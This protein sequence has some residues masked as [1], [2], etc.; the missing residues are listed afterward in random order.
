MITPKIP[1]FVYGGDYNPEQWPEE[2][3]QEDMRLMKQAGVNLVNIGMW[4]WALL[5][6]KE[7]QYTFDYLDRLMD[8]LAK[9]GI[10]ADLATPT[11]APPAWMYLKHPDLNPVNV[12]GLRMNHGSRQTFCPNSP[13]FRQESQKIVRVLAEHYKTHPALAMWHVNNEY[14]HKVILCHCETCAAQF[15]HWLEERY[16]SLSKVNDTWGASFWGQVYY[17]WNEIIPPRLTA[18][19]VNPTLLL[20]YKRFMTDSYLGCY[21]LEKNI[22]REL[23]PNTPVTTN[24]LYEFRTMD[25]FK[26]AKQLDFIAVSAFPDPK[27][28]QHSG[29]AAL[30]ADVMRGLKDQ[31]PFLLIEQAANNVN[32]RMGNTNKRPGVMRLWSYQ[33]IAHGSEGAMFFQWRQSQKGAEKFHSAIV[34]HSGADTRIFREVEQLGQEFKRLGSEILDARVKA[35]VALMIDY[36]NWWTVEYAP[37]PTLYLKYLEQ[38]QNYYYPLYEQNIAVDVVSCL[39]DL[40]KYALVIAPTL[41]MVKPGVKENIE[42][43]VSN[44]GVF[45]TTFSSG[46]ADETDTVF[47]GGYPGPFKEVLGLWVEEFDA[48]KPYMKN[49]VK[50]A[51]PLGQLQNEYG[52]NLWCDMLHPTTAK[53]LATFGEDYYAGWPCIT[54]NQFGQGFAYYIATQP[55][56]NFRKEFLNY[57]CQR[58]NIKPALE[59]P[60]NV[61]VISRVKDGKEFIFVLNH[62]NETVQVPL[63]AGEYEDLLGLKSI[64][65]E[66]VLKPKDV[67]IL[68]VKNP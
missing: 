55:D 48:L 53:T 18:H 38:L 7:G 46:M 9:N 12:N 1:S 40:G 2:I 13:T 66:C 52:C 34:S 29:E 28:T 31:Q 61:E 47:P 68:T 4:N 41:Y 63:P 3:W 20:D 32:W 26:W 60:A 49:K 27:P 45:L 57:L 44:G 25:Y 39:A 43:Y 30:N 42:K 19:Q 22:L 58:F 21:L 64:R 56:V 36:E 50:L 62:K 17:D 15:R 59:A 33:A 6:P 37:C 5:E 65:G 51:Q 23:T 11:A 24:L 35:K 8:L 16:G 14:S 10:Y 54:E 67:A